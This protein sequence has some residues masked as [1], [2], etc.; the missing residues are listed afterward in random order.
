MYNLVLFVPLKGESSK[1]H[2]TSSR[3]PLRVK[4]YRSLNNSCIPFCVLSIISYPWSTRFYRPVW[5]KKN[6]FLLNFIHLKSFNNNFVPLYL[7]VLHVRRSGTLTLLH[8]EWDS[9]KSQCPSFYMLDHFVTFGTL[10]S[11][12]SKCRKSMSV[13]F[14][15]IV[16]WS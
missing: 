14:L 16:W 15:P 2:L 7:L 11:W 12:I 6:F 1:V 8:S 13:Y 4:M 5:P 9:S 3:K 10:Y